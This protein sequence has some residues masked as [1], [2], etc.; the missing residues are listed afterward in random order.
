V[1]RC[2]ETMEGE[3]KVPEV[4]RVPALRAVQKMIELPG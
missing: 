2:L 3:V 4:V 1:L